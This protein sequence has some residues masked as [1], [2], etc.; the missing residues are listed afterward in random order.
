MILEGIHF[1]HAHGQ[2]VGAG[3]GQIGAMVE[4]LLA[5]GL[6]SMEEH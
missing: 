5:L 6:D 2:T 3:F 4:P 1:R